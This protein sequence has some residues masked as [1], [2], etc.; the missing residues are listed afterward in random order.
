MNL[1]IGIAGDRLRK[2]A[3]NSALIMRLAIAA[4]LSKEG[5]EVFQEYID[6]IFNEPKIILV[7][8][9]DLS[10]FGLETR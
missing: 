8:P 3:A 9:E 5:Q 7:K 6:K 1:L 4:N 10:S 2:D